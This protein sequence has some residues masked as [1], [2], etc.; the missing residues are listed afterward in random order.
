[1]T[2]LAP[3]EIVDDKNVIVQVDSPISFQDQ[4]PNTEGNLTYMLILYGIAFGLVW[5]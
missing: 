5:S 3:V 1:M 4:N 2:K